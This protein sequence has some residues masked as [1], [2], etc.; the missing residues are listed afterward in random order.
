MDRSLLLKSII[1]VK[2]HAD[3]GSFG[4]SMEPSLRE[5]DFVRLRK[6]GNPLVGAIV[7]FPGTRS[8]LPI[9]H[10]VCGMDEGGAYVII[11]DGKSS[12]SRRISDEIIGV[13]THVKLRS[14]GEWRLISY[15]IIDSQIA[16]CSIALAE[17]ASDSPNA[18]DDI[19]LLRVALCEK[20][21][22]SF[23]SPCKGFP[24]EVRRRGGINCSAPGMM[25]ARFEDGKVVVPASWRDDDDE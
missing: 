22:A 5:G 6:C 23:L 15:G 9:L 24:F 14:S 11:G 3:V 4:K 16:E 1:T 12:V 21:R 20:W 7:A 25:S 8:G 18:G 10:R 2:G 19:R 13:A 17:L